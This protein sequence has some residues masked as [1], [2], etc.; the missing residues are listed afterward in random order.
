[1]PRGNSNH[2]QLRPAEIILT[3]PINVLKFFH[4]RLIAYTRLSFLFFWM[5]G[6]Q[7]MHSNIKICGFM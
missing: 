1:M 4:V 6:F 3:C 5:D 2:G 7:N